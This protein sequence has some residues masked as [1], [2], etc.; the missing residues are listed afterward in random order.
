MLDELRGIRTVLTPGMRV[1]TANAAP[2]A[3]NIQLGRLQNAAEPNI[4]RADAAQPGQRG[5]IFV[6]NLNINVQEVADLNPQEINRQINELLDLQN[7]NNGGVF[8]DNR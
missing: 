5:G 4:N 8:P 6:E 7:R 3:P 1:A 2:N